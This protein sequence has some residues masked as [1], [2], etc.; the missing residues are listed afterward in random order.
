M[1]KTKK[2][3][4]PLDVNLI[5]LP[6]WFSC[7]LSKE[8]LREPIMSCG[9]GKLYNKESVLEYFVSGRK[10]GDASTEHLKSIKVSFLLKIFIKI[11]L[12]KNLKIKK[13]RI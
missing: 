11:C 7:S 10:G 6:Q 5:L 12:L 13:N 9:L 2:K 4:S 8:P 1:V 3:S